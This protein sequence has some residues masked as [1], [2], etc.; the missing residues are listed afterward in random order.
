MKVGLSDK[1]R[2][3]VITKFRYLGDTIVATP[4]LRRL[5]EA[6]PTSEITVLGG[7]SI[8][9]LLAGCPYI[10]E[11]WGFDPEQ[12]EA[13]NT[14]Q[15]LTRIHGAAFDTVF[16]LNR[17][18][19]SALIA[20]RAK[21]PVRIGHATEF[22][23]PLLTHRVR[24]EWGRHDRECALDLLRR[25]GIPAESALPELWVSEQERE[26]ARRMLKNNGVEP[27]RLL[28]GM[29]PGANDPDI[30]E[31]GAVRF[32][33][34]ASRLAAEHNAH[35]VLLGAKDE[36]PVSDEVAADFR[37]FENRK[38]QKTENPAVLTGET[39]LRQVLSIIALCDLWIGNDGG[40]LHAAVGLGPAT[41]G[42]F[43]PTKARRWGYDDPRH[44]TMVVYPD[45]GGNP[46]APVIRR[47]L[48]AITTDA[49]YDAAV[50]T[51]SAAKS[52]C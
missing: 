19:H 25:T 22:R 9:S 16:L 18:V 20:F 34:V 12:R 23:G 47:C 14:G 7:P 39:D 40:L 21:I 44:K 38:N 48:D 1:S 51:L 50:T 49:V 8:P 29:Q 43:G 24:Y 35:V 5:Y 15:I 36:R 31:W 17:S 32:A 46:D 33:E 37:Q 41:V 11:A 3:L 27:G 30:R 42:I 6:F 28:V 52:K 13:S 45:G 26:E 10:R 4:F 2:I